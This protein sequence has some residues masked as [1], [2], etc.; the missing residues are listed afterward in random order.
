MWSPVGDAIAYFH[1]ADGIVDLRLTRLEGTAPE[2]RVGETINLTDV[3]ALDGGSRPGWF[4]PE[5]QL[6]PLPTPAANSPAATWDAP[7]GAP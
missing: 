1:E 3:S 7:S 4:V 2:W 5:G 6:P